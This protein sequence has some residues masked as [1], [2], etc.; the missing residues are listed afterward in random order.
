MLI[1]TCVLKKRSTKVYFEG[2]SR[3]LSGKESLLPM[4][5][6]QGTWVRSLGWEDPP[7]KEM[8][9]HSS[10]LAWEIPW[11]KEPGGLQSMGSQ[12]R[13]WLSEHVHGYIV[14]IRTENMARY[15]TTLYHLPQSRASGQS[16]EPIR[17]ANGL[18][19]REYLY[20][21]HLNP[22]NFSLNLFFNVRSVS[23]FTAVFWSE[24]FKLYILLVLN[25][26]NNPACY[27]WI[28]LL[29]VPPVCWDLFSLVS[30]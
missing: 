9:T 11:T 26:E 21:S 20:A 12:S 6:P 19:V 3:G 15:R 27:I 1:T 18:T 5:E 13:T 17:T 4:Q 25:N 7:E 22:L 10:T 28:N 23:L 2:F 29:Y 30:F 16:Q 8:A 24:L 14:L